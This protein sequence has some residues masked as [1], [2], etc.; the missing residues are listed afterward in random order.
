[1][2]VKILDI[3]DSSVTYATGYEIQQNK[4]GY[5]ETI[6]TWVCG[7]DHDAVCKTY[8]NALAELKSLGDTTR[9]GMYRLVSRER[10]TREK[11]TLMAE[12]SSQ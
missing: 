1:M 4:K 12:V 10:E 5:W 2:N 8:E 7:D 11:V 9:K 6:S 3:I